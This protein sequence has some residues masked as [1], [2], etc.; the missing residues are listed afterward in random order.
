M[1]ALTCCRR[2]RCCRKVC[3]LEEQLA[4]C[5]CKA[6][7]GHPPPNLPT[8]AIARERPHVQV[9]G[10]DVASH[11]V[12]PVDGAQTPATALPRLLGD[13]TLVP[14]YRPLDAPTKHHHALVEGRMINPSARHELL[15]PVPLP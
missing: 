7:L 3:V 15:Q 5:A 10:V 12:P 14:V 11:A 8:L 4:G 6:Q 2:Y 9:L 1:S 13:E